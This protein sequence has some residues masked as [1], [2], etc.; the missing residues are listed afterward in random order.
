MR[1][2]LEA[3]SRTFEAQAGDL[4]PSSLQRYAW[5][6]AADLTLCYLPSTVAAHEAG[7]TAP[8]DGLLTALHANQAHCASDEESKAWDEAIRLAEAALKGE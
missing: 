4:P 2:K 6:A 8:G 1:A 7:R 3:L 5:E